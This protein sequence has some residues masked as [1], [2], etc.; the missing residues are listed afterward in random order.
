MSRENHGYRED[1]DYQPPDYGSES[2]E[3]EREAY[4]T[5]KYSTF[6]SFDEKSMPVN[7]GQA[8]RKNPLR[9]KTGIT[10]KKNEYSTLL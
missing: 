7:T 5:F 2:K 6:K 4:D 8:D 9:V 3:D 1:Q 10:F